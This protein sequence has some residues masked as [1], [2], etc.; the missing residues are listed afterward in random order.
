MSTPASI[1]IIQNEQVVSVSQRSDGYPTHLLKNVAHW[2]STG[3]ADKAHG[4]ASNVA[5]LR[6][7]HLMSYSEEV[8]NGCPGLEMVVDLEPNLETDTNTWC[9][10]V[11]LDSRNIKVFCNDTFIDPRTENLTIC[12]LQYLKAILDKH[13]VAEESEI[14]AII[15]DLADAGFTIN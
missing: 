13:V 7:V 14:R 6:H 2:I 3:G 12:P 9:Y 4:L 8:R 15:T 1:Q 10:V 5:S 11:D